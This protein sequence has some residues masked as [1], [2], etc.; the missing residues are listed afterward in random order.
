MQIFQLFTFLCGVF[1]FRAFFS[2]FAPFFLWS[3][4]GMN[5]WEVGQKSETLFTGVFQ[6]ADFEFEV[7]FAKNKMSEPLGWVDFFKFYM[8]SQK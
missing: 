8:I 4:S 1:S 6:V 3:H 5:V 7:V 2:S